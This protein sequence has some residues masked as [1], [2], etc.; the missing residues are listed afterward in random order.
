VDEAAI[1]RNQSTITREER[2]KP[3]SADTETTSAL[4]KSAKTDEGEVSEEGEVEE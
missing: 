4:A 2:R 1:I 3:Q